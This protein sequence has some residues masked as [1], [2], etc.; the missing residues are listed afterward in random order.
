MSKVDER[1]KLKVLNFPIFLDTCDIQDLFKKFEPSSCTINRN[2]ILHAILEFKNKKQ[3]QE[4]L[5]NM[6]EKLYDGNK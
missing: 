3:A 5:E 1:T 4:C 2:G 6:N